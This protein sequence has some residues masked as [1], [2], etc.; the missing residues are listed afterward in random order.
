MT[1]T[2]A[3]TEV[4]TEKIIIRFSLFFMLMGLRDPSMGWNGFGQ[5]FLNWVGLKRTSI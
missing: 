5:L 4:L 1:G 3:L 2:F